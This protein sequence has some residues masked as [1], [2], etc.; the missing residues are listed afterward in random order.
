[1]RKSIRVLTN[2]TDN[3]WK[4]DHSEMKYLAVA[5]RATS[6]GEQISGLLAPGPLLSTI[7]GFFHY[8]PKLM[9]F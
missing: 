5:Q 1:M 2:Y 8:D 9:F 6:K 7:L 3:G 4:E